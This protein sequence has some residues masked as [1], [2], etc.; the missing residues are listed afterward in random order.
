MTA[1]GLPFP[2]PDREPA[3]DVP[4]FIPQDWTAPA[5]PAPAAVEPAGPT[6]MPTVHEPTAPSGPAADESA[7]GDTGN[8][9]LGSRVRALAWLASQQQRAELSNQRL[10]A[11][12]YAV[13]A[14]VALF[15]QT[16]GLVEKLNLPDVGLGLV[17][18]PRQLIALGLALAIELVGVVLLSTADVRRI[19]HRERAL[20]GRLFALAV[21]GMVAYINYDGHKDNPYQQAVFTGA[22]L[23]AFGI[24]LWRGMNKRRDVL[25]QVGDMAAPTPLY[26]WR[27]YL[28]QAWPVTARA[29]ELAKRNPG[30]GV[31]GSLRAAEDELARQRRHAA[32]TTAIRA[33]IAAHVDPVTADIAIASYDL[34]AI[35]ERLGGWADNTGMA[36]LLATDLTPDRLTAPTHGRTRGGSA[37]PAHRSGEPTQ[38]G[39][40]EPDVS[41]HGLADAPAPDA[42]RQG[43][44]ES[45]RRGRRQSAE[46][47]DAV[48]SDRIAT[49]Y[50]QL[51][52]QL[53]RE[54]SGAELA[55]ASGTSKATCNRWKR[56]RASGGE[57]R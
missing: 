9:P 13:L 46:P 32:L 11:V 57:S 41:T 3:V 34:D 48:T 1:T 36:T 5:E 52:D 35:A 30:L 19:Y 20:G 10:T 21:A 25:R 6:P 16:E 53:G 4:D 37:T 17:T 54:P 14:G 42:H 26:P 22:S 40:G 33:R 47:A 18:L 44:R 49:Q 29:R 45:G 23:V 31:Y 28:P 56:D 12:L 27:C 8:Q 2:D 55:R 38:P 7:T 15:G 51:S 24:W 43:R 39:A 50:A